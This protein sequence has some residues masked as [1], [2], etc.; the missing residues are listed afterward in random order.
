MNSKPSPVTA[1]PPVATRVDWVDTAKGICIILVVMMHTTL[2]LEKASGDTGWMHAVVEFARPFRMPDFFMISGLFLAATIDRPWRLYLDRKVVHFFYFY[3]LWVAIQFAFKAPFM[4][5][6]G[7]SAGMVFR[8]FLFTSVQPFG[9]LWFIYMLPVFFLVTRLFRNHAWW[10]F[11]AAVL[12]QMAPVNSTLILKY[13]TT[14]LHVTTDDSHWVLIDEFCSFF[15]YFLGGYLFAPHIFR[16][17]EYAR[18][19]ITPSLAI[20]AGWFALNLSLVVLGWSTLPIVSLALGAAGAMAIVAAASLLVQ[21]R[22]TRLLTHTGANSIVVYLAFFLPMIIMRLIFL[23]FAP[24]VD[25]GTMAFVSTAVG[26]ITPMIG[27]WFIRKI[28]FGLFL[29]HRPQWAIFAEP[30]RRTKASLQPAE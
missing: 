17:A 1:A 20:L 8:S 12:L 24:W 3:V 23:K 6:D 18:T 9:T 16:F 4:V 30:P 26:V 28:G 13:L 10:L 2:G 7:Q 11:G 15:V 19:N 5:A 14:A 29:F 21:M 22:F 27:Y 25:P